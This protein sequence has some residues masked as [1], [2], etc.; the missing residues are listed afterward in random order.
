MRRIPDLLDKLRALEGRPYGFYKD[1]KG[2]W[3]GEG[4]SLRFVHVQGDPFATPSVVEVRLSPAFHRIPP[5]S[6]G[7]RGA[8]PW[9]ISS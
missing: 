7:R 2:S 5:S 9:R 8:L 1:L 4:F 6:A 3:Q